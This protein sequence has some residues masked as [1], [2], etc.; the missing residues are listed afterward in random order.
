M[1]S[2][3]NEDRDGPR[4]KRGRGGGGG[5]GKG[6]Q[7]KGKPNANPRTKRPTHFICLPLVTESS[8]PQL[9]ESLA[10]FRSVTT[11]L[12]DST[13]K[14]DAA[15]R[16]PEAEGGPL[17]AGPSTA[18]TSNSTRLEA[19]AGTW[20]GNGNGSN[21]GGGGTSTIR[22][23]ETLRLIPSG[24][25]RPPGT[26]HLTLGTMDLS[27]QEDMDMALRLL[28]D[29]DYVQLLGGAERQMQREMQRQRQMTEEEEDG[30]L[31]ERDRP[32]RGARMMM[33]EAPSSVKDAN[34]GQQHP[35][36]EQEQAETKR[37][38]GDHHGE[39]R[40]EDNVEKEADLEVVQVEPATDSGGNDKD[41]K[42]NGNGKGVVQAAV[43]EAIKAPLQSLAR[44]IS[45]PPLTSSTP[46]SASTSSRPAFSGSGSG[47]DRGSLTI[48]L[49]GLGTF[50][51][52]S[53]SRIFYAN[54]QDPSGRLLPFGQLVRQRFQDAGLVT[55]TRPLVLHATVA[56]FIYDRTNKKGKGKARKGPGGGGG[57]GGGGG[58]SG[59]DA[60][61][62]LRFFNDGGAVRD[63]M[64]RTGNVAK[65]FARDDE[66]D[67]A[68]GKEREVEKEEDD[69]HHHH[70]LHTHQQRHQQHKIEEVD[71]ED[72]GDASSSNAMSKTE[73][74]AVSEYIW[75]RDIH[76]DRIRI[77][78]MGAEKSDHEGWGLEYKA[79]GEKLFVP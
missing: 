68:D 40:G 57:G 6:Q 18:S 23:D 53:S 77:C 32:R 13:S 5:W 8:I 15:G 7:S 1:A 70:H 52:A 44:S 2:D 55:E 65:T 33:G 35:V 4:S 49:S 72:R 73:A 62:I 71:D 67:A 69:H 19:G 20:T 79:V 25:H 21:T 30:V 26:F 74:E 56:N 12:L 39:H 14:N 36:K 42:R 31:R 10:H 41:D 46:P 29:I 66:A 3:D 17:A 47:S 60:R 9:S 11:P 61:D 75:A 59:V 58:M 78:K 22:R 27:E 38:G 37:E 51:R 50:P 34:D 16:N 63:R 64:A 76:V 24:A 28:Q 54:P 43:K 48:T 45:P